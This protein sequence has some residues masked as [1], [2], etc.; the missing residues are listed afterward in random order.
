[1]S[2]A[3]SPA[4]L[5]KIFRIAAPADRVFRALTNPDELRHWFAEHAEV[6]LRPGGSYAF[7]GVLSP[8]TPRERATQKIIEVQPD[9]LLSYSWHWRELDGTVTLTLNSSGSATSLHILH[10]GT[11]SI[12]DTCENTEFAMLDFWRLSIGNLRSYLKT[13]K[14]ALRP[15]F[16]N[17]GERVAMSI[18]IDAP[19]AAVY[20]A[21]TDPGQ[22]DKWISTAAT[23]EPRAGGTYNYG[24]KFGDP[25]AHCGPRRILAIE[26]GRIIEHDW[27]HA[28]EPTTR[29]R[30]E[31]T[32]IAP[33]RTR[34]DLTH[35][36][37]AEDDSTRGGYLAGW[38]AFLHML[39]QF[40]EDP[41]APDLR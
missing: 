28:K 2:A 39:K 1:M 29:V 17:K 37:P 8:W 26:P 38:S 16:E 22:M 24:W 41:H 25:P 6:Q 31:L 23:V 36:R 13:G 7:W 30:W 5:E 11:G 34:V 15:S 4:R 32:E 35:I 14:A 27:D 12:L 19:P 33:G 18:E 20:R 40:G 10:Q 21:L 3:P 9:R